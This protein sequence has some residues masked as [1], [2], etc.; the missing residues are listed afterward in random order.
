MNP[1]LLF[2]WIHLAI[3]EQGCISL[4]N[5][6]LEIFLQTMNT[7]II[8]TTAWMGM[9]VTDQLLVDAESF[10]NQKVIKFYFSMNVKFKLTCGIAVEE[11]WMFTCQTVWTI[12]GGLAG[13]DTTMWVCD[14]AV[15]LRKPII[16]IVIFTEVVFTFTVV[17]SFPISVTRAPVCFVSFYKQFIELTAGRVYGEHLV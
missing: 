15:L 1:K 2:T 10:K 11:V 14:L 16:Q 13:L 7:F 17:T 9:A 3:A 4:D 6:L 8:P 5:P 12:I